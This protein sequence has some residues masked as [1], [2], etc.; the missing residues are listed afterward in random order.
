VRLAVLFQDGVSAGQASLIGLKA[1]VP[2]VRRSAALVIWH[3]WR[4]WLAMSIEYGRMMVDGIRFIDGV[5]RIV[6]HRVASHCSAVSDG[7]SERVISDRDMN[8][9]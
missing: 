5:H 8:K 3:Q 1:L 7:G 6:S 9:T 4:A 2:T